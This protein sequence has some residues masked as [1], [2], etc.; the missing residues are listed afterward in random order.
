MSWKN[1]ATGSGATVYGGWA[2][3]RSISQTGTITTSLI[4][5]RYLDVVH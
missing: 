5:Y 3:A 1:P 2:S 4:T